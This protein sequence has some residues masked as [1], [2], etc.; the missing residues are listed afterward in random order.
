MILGHGINL[1]KHSWISPSYTLSFSYNHWCRP[2]PASPCPGVPTTRHLWHFN[3]WKMGRGCREMTKLALG[4]MFEKLS[5]PVWG[6][7]FLM[8]HSYPIWKAHYVSGITKDPSHVLAY[9]ILLTSLWG[10]LYNPTIIDEEMKAKKRLNNLPKVELRHSWTPKHVFFPYFMT[11][12][13]RVWIRSVPHTSLECSSKF[14]FSKTQSI[15]REDVRVFNSKT[16][17]PEAICPATKCIPSSIRKFYFFLCHQGRDAKNTHS[18]VG[19]NIIL[20]YTKT[21]KLWTLEYIHLNFNRYPRISPR[22][23][24]MNCNLAFK[25]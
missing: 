25:R 16:E 22:G 13:Y 5:N 23:T 10:G 21:F 12:N 7:T 14:C 4:N 1:L 15:S 20:N 6:E 11:L 17:D 3:R 8:S 2:L 24:L 18:V 9:L 19:T